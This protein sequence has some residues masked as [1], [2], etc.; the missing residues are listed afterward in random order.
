MKFKFETILI[1]V[2]FVLCALV[3]IVLRF[4]SSDDKI[5]YVSS[6]QSESASTSAD[7]TENKET[8]ESTKSIETTTFVT[9]TKSESSD[10]IN[11]NTA[12]L[13]ELKS[14][15]GIGDV[16][17]QRIIDYRKITPFTNVDEIINVK[18]IGIKKRDAIIDKI[19]V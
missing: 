2:A 19:V 15:D 4:D 6:S 8:V 14:L 13:D 16:L 7:L 1:C 9:K 11:I 18:G 5:Q 12:T 3:V 17:A 10:K